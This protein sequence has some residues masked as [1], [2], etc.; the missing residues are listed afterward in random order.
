MNNICLA[1]NRSKSSDA[2]YY[3]IMSVFPILYITEVLLG[4]FDSEHDDTTILRIFGRYLPKDAK[5]H[6]KDIKL[7]QRY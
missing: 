3:Y 7:P 6:H 2:R 1:S 5:L 4:L